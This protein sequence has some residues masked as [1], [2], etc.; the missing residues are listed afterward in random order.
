MYLDMC[1]PREIE[2]AK[3]NNTPVVI[4]GGTVEY[5]GPQCSYGC[6]TLV[7]QGL[8][9]RLAQKKDIIIAPS[10]SYSPASYAVGGETSGTVHVE[11]NAFE[12]YVYYVF[13][14]MLSAGLRNI[15]VVIHHQYEQESLMPMTL[16]YMK[17]AKRA[18]MAYLEKT[19]GQGWWGSEAYQD[20]YANLETSDNPFG[21]IKVIPTMNT[22][23]QNATGYD[24]AGK[25]ECSILMALY[26]E[27]VRPERLGERAHWF[28]KSAAEAN[29]ELGEEMV[30]LA[31]EY[32]ER[33]IL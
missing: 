18:T 10:I 32:L 33:T 29:K 1:F 12:Q 22:A 15:Y 3:E 14:S 26:P 30:R 21:W 19:R 7:A 5:H 23:V 6:D 4:V 2:A 24:H 13:M 16:C 27:A 11:E 17:A 9:E 25:Y 20:Y 28:T 31:L 8:V